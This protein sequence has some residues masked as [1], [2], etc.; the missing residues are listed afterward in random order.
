VFISIPTITGLNSQYSLS[1]LFSRIVLFVKMPNR[2]PTVVYPPGTPRRSPRLILLHENN[3]PTTPKPKSSTISRPKTVRVRKSPNLSD[4]VPSLRRSPRF[5]K[6]N[7]V[8]VSEFGSCDS[9]R[10]T[11][12]EGK[13]KKSSGGVVVE[14]GR[15]RRRKHGGDGIEEGRKKEEIEGGVEGKRK[16]DGG[17]EIVEELRKEEVEC[18]VKRK[19]KR[20]GG[21][22]AQG[23]TKEQELALRTAYFTAKPSPHFWKNV[24]KLV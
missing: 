21:E 2:N 13:E 17:G 15:K 16:R 10:K 1:N 8:K 14:G 23:W 11:G 12:R 4:Q 19:R 3:N 6:K 18:G 9:M 7:D 24:S 5:S 22:V 20:G